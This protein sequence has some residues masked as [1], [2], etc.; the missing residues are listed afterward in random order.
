M[1]SIGYVK[2]VDFGLAKVIDRGKTWT[3]CGTPAYLAPEIVLNDGHDWAVDYWALGVFLFE[4]T[5]G[6]E[7]FAAKSPME[8]YKQIVSGYVEI[9]PDFS[10]SLADLIKKLLNSSKSKRLGRTMGGGGAVMQHRWYSDFDWDG[11]LEKRLAVPL[12]PKTQ[13]TLCEDSFTH[14]SASSENHKN[15]TIQQS[16]ARSTRIKWQNAAKGV[17]SATR[18][19]YALGQ[20]NRHAQTVRKMMD[21]SAEKHDSA[22]MTMMRVIK[23]DS[24]ERWSNYSANSSTRNTSLGEES[25]NSTDVIQRMRVLVAYKQKGQGRSFEQF[26]LLSIYPSSLVN[27]ESELCAHGYRFLDSFITKNVGLID[28]FPSGLSES[29]IDSEA[30]AA[31]CF[32]N[33]LKIRLIPRCAEASARR[34][35][36]LGEHGDSYQLQGFTDAAGSLTHGCAITIREEFTHKEAP[37]VLSV[38]SLHRQRRRSAVVIARWLQKHQRVSSRPVVKTTASL[39]QRAGTIRWRK[40]RPT[41][42]APIQTPS[43]KRRLRKCRSGQE[44]TFRESLSKMADETDLSREEYDVEDYPEHIRRLGISAYQAMVD[45]EKIGNICIVE[46]CYVFTRTRLQ[47]QSLLFC[48][49]Q[50]LIEMERTSNAF[51]SENR[52]R[53]LSMLQSTLSLAPSQRRISY[54]RSELDHMSNPQRRFD[55]DPGMGMSKISLP[56]PLPHVSGEWGLATLFLRIKDSGLLILL[57][58]LLLERSVLIIGENPE[59]VTACTTVLLG[60]LDPYKWASAFIPL[61]PMDMLDFVGSPVPFIAGMIAEGK[62]HLQSIIHD[63]IVKEAMLNGLSIVNLASGKLIVTRE[64]GTSDILRR[65]FQTIPTLSLYQ[66]RLDLYC[67]SPS[68]NLR[69]FRLFFKHGA[70]R[71]ESLTLRKIRK[72]VKDHM[73]QYTV[74]LRDKPEAWR[75]YGSFNEAIGAYDFCPDKFIQPLKDSMI[76]QIQYQEMMAHTQLFLGYVES[77]QLAHEERSS[78]LSGPAAHLIAHWVQVHWYAKYKR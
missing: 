64:K 38:L 55:I 52:Q 42:P 34:L 8:V 58:L 51:D 10:P 20:G 31:F 71:K 12:Q 14:S 18:L 61:L 49:L 76:F 70:S 2:I 39:R 57:K 4:M 16:S 75:Q 1:D 43:D 19:T 50:N 25:I 59:E 37:D 66:K 60:L 48:A 27:G 72:I 46:K 5:S 23:Q 6:K 3:L 40:K 33:G 63:Q 69:S 35:G 7:P 26:S 78:L 36:W 68:S 21:N 41:D 47:D 56:L 30:L 45:A 17:A 13:E 15:A 74:G 54:P 32:P 65:S 73:A 11:M 62:K 24:C 44:G 29:S 28:Q 67:K 22:R 53:V 9:P 77:L